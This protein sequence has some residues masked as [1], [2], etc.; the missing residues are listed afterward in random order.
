MANGGL[1]PILLKICV[2]LT[3]LVVALGAYAGDSFFSD[4]AY[5]NAAQEEKLSAL[6]TR[7]RDHSDRIARV[8]TIVSETRDQL[9]DLRGRSARQELKLDRLIELQLERKPKGK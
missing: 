5:Q 8:E 2:W 4:I 3:S 9:L 1:D 6:A 7:E